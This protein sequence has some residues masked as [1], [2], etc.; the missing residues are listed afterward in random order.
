MQ[1]KDRS[2]GP[3][4][5]PRLASYTSRIR[6]GQTMI[7]YSGN[8]YRDF[9]R[10]QAEG[11]KEMH[12]K[13]DTIRIQAPERSW[14]ADLVGGVWQWL[15]GCDVCNGRPRGTSFYL[16]DCNEHNVC[17]G[18]SRHHSEFSEEVWAGNA[19]WVCGPCNKARHEKEKAAALAAMPD[20]YDASDFYGRDDVVC[21]YCA[22]EIDGGDYHQADSEVVQCERCDHSFKVSAD[23][24]VTYT[25][26][27]MTQEAHS[28]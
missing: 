24:S 14:Y 2:M 25:S 28:E 16:S 3:I 26:E 20:E 17:A 7:F 8:D 19:G 23:Y 9:D 15:D 6:S 1:S 22:Y 21:P 11:R 4:E 13:P 18:C 12:D 27:R 10:Y 5:D